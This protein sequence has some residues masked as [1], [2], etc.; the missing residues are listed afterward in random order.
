MHFA[1]PFAPAAAIIPV[2]GIADYA[3]HAFAAGLERRRPRCAGTVDAAGLRKTTPHGQAVHA[4]RATG[5]YPTTDRPGQ[6]GVPAPGGCRRR[7]LAGPGPFLRHLRPDHAA[8]P[9]GR[10]PGPRL[11]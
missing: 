8:H 1:V 3:S 9:G 7:E 2:D 10:G 5:E 4:A 6:R 11:P